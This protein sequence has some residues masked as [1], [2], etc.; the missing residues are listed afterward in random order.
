MRLRIVGGLLAALV[1]MGMVLTTEAFSATMTEYQTVAN[2]FLAFVNSAKTTASAEILR[3]NDIAPAEPEVEIACL[4]QLNG[5]GFVFIAASKELTPVKAYSL[6]ADFD[7]LPPP[8]RDFLLKE[9]EYNARTVAATVAA[10]STAAVSQARQRWDF[11]LNYDPNRATQAYTPNE[12][13]LTTQWNQGAP[14]DKYLPEI[15][16]DRVLAGCVNVAMAQVMRHHAHPATGKG[17]ESYTWNGQTL[18]AVLYRPYNW[19]N[20]PDKAD[21]TQPTHKIDEIARLFRDLAIV[22]HT[23]LG[24]DSSG[25]SVRIRA[26]VENFGYAATVK[27]MDNWSGEATVDTFFQTIRSEIDVERPVLLS[28]PG[29]MTVADGYSDNATGR[30]IHVNFGWGG[31]SDGFYFLD[32][33]VAAGNSTFAPVLDIYYDIK[34]CFDDNCMTAL[35]TGCTVDGNVASGRFDY[36]LDVDEHLIYLSGPT[37]LTGDRGYTNQAFYLSVFDSDNN[38]IASDQMPLN[39]DSDNPLPPDLYR[40][41]VSLQGEDGTF[42][43]YD[44]LVDYTVDIATTAL[45]AG[46]REAVDATLDHPPVIFNDF[47]DL[48]LKTDDTEPHRILV[49]AR[50]ENGDPLTLTV[51]QTHA[52][53]VSVVL[54]SNVLALSPSPGAAGAASQIIVRAEANGQVTEKSFIAMVSDQELSFGKSYTVGGVFA[55]QTESDRYRI[56]LDGACTLSG[57]NGFS[58]QAFFTTVRELDESVVT[59]PAYTSGGVGNTAISQTF[60]TGTYFLDASLYAA[61]IGQF[62]Y[63]QGSNDSYWI[64]VSCPEADDS[65]AT[66]AGLLGVDMGGT[67]LKPGDTNRDGV[68]NLI[69]AVIVLKSMSGIG[70]NSGDVSV[71]ADVNG[72]ARIG[73]AELIHILQT[74]SSLR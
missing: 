1:G 3:A 49:D 35:E 74:A 10:R 65:T 19:A 67:L 32:T 23:S 5:G 40:I 33:T 27:K 68:V 8:Y 71:D 34:P 13:L 64:D 52:G 6:K 62:P 17:V 58:N 38:L 54:D 60:T 53:A 69:D 55:H 11:L 29:H 18:K 26:L 48:L 72:D 15:G 14:Y 42:Y 44:T 50:D 30:E 63:E 7:T 25:A 59:G 51:H 57:Y 21:S 36:E 41:R 73:T 4:F 12:W 24:T 56:V 66:I 2:N 61:G 22:N 43:N 28:F 39:F 9:A 47:V 20:M 70:L 45:A 37:T 46:E 31:H 16:G